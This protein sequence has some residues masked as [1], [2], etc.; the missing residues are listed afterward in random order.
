MSITTFEENGI[1][2]H[3]VSVAELAA[4]FEDDAKAGA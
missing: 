1:I 4:A 2:I 3:S